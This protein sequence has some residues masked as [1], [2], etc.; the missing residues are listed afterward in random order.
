MSNEIEIADDFIKGAR[1]CRKGKEARENASDDYNRGYSAEYAL[2]QAITH[3]SELQE[4][5]H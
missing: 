4:V 3:F 5:L 1:D 2:E